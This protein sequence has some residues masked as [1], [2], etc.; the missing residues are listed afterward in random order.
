[1]QVHDINSDV[2]S[3]T[4]GER[5]DRRCLAPCAPS[6]TFRPSPSHLARYVT[7]TVLVSYLADGK[8]HTGLAWYEC[9]PRY[10][11]MSVS[12]Y[13]RFYLFLLM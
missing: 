5:C 6:R 3:S 13:R 9:I 7:V 8:L 1:M 11:L 10:S 12:V 4:C 2:F